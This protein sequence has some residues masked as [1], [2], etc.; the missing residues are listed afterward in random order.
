VYELSV[1]TDFCAAHHL[2]NYQGKCAS[3]HGHNWKVRIKLT[4]S[5]LNES[6]M[7]GD[8]GFYRNELAS[9]VKQLDHKNLNDADLLQGMNPTCENVSRRIYEELAPRIN[10]GKVTLAAVSV[11]EKEGSCVTYRC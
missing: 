7:L 8:F 6:G 1:E 10:S 2:V 5:E 3:V 11:W 4:G 9:V